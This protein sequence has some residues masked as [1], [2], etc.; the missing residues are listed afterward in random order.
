MICAS[1]NFFVLIV[2][3]FILISSWYHI[4]FP[5]ITATANQFWKSRIRE[6]KA[7]EITSIVNI[8]TWP[9]AGNPTLN[10]FSL[11]V[12]LVLKSD[13]LQHVSKVQLLNYAYTYLHICIYTVYIYSKPGVD[14]YLKIVFKYST[15][16]TFD[17]CATFWQQVGDNMSQKVFVLLLIFKWLHFIIISVLQ[18]WGLDSSRYALYQIYQTGSSATSDKQYI[19]FNNTTDK[20]QSSR[21]MPI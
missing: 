13:D 6:N 16:A 10:K 17:H 21:E 1:I 11:Y 3:I 5:F 8:N 14:R 4:F 9:S 12:V 2:L 15:W 7:G 18:I 20:A 19:F